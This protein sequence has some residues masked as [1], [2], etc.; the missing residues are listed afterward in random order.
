ML[1][2]M[3]AMWT[4]KIIILL[5]LDFTGFYLVNSYSLLPKI[6]TNNIEKV[7]MSSSSNVDYK[8]WM[9]YLE[10]RLQNM[11]ITKDLRQFHKSNFNVKLFKQ[12]DTI[13][14]SK[15]SNKCE[16]IQLDIFGRICGSSRKGKQVLGQD[17]CQYIRHITK[18]MSCYWDRGKCLIY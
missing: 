16:G 5:S 10:R 2:L 14:K 1:S 6:L 7:I 12:K 17:T 9:K 13:S 15:C 8:L 3:L 4:L 11:F 18:R